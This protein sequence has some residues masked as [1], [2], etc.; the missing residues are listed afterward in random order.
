MPKL[1]F[2]NSSCWVSLKSHEENVHQRAKDSTGPFPGCCYSTRYK[3]K[4]SQH[5]RNHNPDPLIRRPF[6]CLF[7]GC[8][9]SSSTRSELKNHSDALHNPNC[10]KTLSSPLC[11]NTFYSRSGVTLHVNG[12]HLKEKGYICDKCGYAT[13]HPTELKLH[14]L[15][16]HDE[17]GLRNFRFTCQSC[18]FH[19]LSTG[20][21]CTHIRIV[22]AKDK[23]LRHR[24]SLTKLEDECIRK[25]AVV[26]LSRMCKS[27]NMLPKLSTLVLML[28][29]RKLL[30]K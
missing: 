5:L 8:Q 18:G 13:G 1:Q 16:M 24:D 4:L 23:G 9:Y 27:C 14:H 22:H 6:R 15:R 25:V 11:S 7:T 29:S 2:Q 30:D 20:G 26:L 19:A 17:I 3:G 10:T 12:T 28:F 21:L